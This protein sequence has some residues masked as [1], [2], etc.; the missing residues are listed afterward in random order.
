MPILF[1]KIVYLVETR[2]RASVKELRMETIARW[3]RTALFALCLM[4]LMGLA[5]AARSLAWQ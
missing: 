3:V 4:L 5:V 2:G 1:K